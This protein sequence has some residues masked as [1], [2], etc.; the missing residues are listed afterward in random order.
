MRH[1]CASMLLEGGMPTKYVADWLGHTTTVMV[2]T[3]RPSLP[4]VLGLLGE[5]L[6][7]PAFDSTEFRSLVQENLAQIEE[8]KSE[9]SARASIA[10]RRYLNPFPKGD[11]R[12]T[13]TLDEQAADL[14]DEPFVVSE[15]GA[16]KD[17]AA[18]P[19]G[20]FL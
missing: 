17:P 6:R 14:D 18:P 16:A 13:A 8:Q 10:L 5:V 19:A 2:E 12:Y 3:T 20:L 7:E 15:S 4:A 1:Y 11:P 9:P